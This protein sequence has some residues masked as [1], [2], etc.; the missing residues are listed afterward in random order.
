M[1]NNTEWELLAKY[2]SGECSVSE[3]EKVENWLLSDPENSQVIDK[4]RKI[5]E[6]SEEE[7]EPSDINAMWRNLSEKAGIINEFSKD[8][9]FNIV[10]QK[11]KK[12]WSDILLNTPKL[13]RYAAVIIFIILIPSLIYIVSL[14]HDDEIILNWKSIIVEEGKQSQFILSDGTK[15]ILDAGSSFQY[16]ENFSETERKVKLNGEAYFEVTHNLKNPFV[17]NTF[18]A[19]VKVLGTKFNV[20]AWENNKNVKVA[21]T[22]GKVSLGKVSEKSDTILISKG[23]TGEL[24]SDGSLMPPKPIDVAKSLSWLNGEIYFEDSNLSEVL[25]QMERWFDV[26][27]TLSDSTILNER[28]SVFIQKKSLTD[29]LEII[30]ELT[31]SQYE[32]TGN[33]III[34]SINSTIIR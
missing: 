32:Q 6:T 2:L 21:V 4:M 8:K 29:A 7:F 11:N 16:P 31:D 25:L 18:N 13:L 15:V 33:K 9:I 3:I 5:W 26:S 17:V 34:K 12:S 24:L 14:P 27:I 19:I 1:N 23:F 30:T 20:R 28:V 22:E 10:P